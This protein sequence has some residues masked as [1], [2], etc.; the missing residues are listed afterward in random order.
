VV[1]ESA[2]HQCFQQ[3]ACLPQESK[4]L[5]FPYVSARLKPYPPGDHL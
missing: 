4:P 2:P 3:P 1:L 5:N